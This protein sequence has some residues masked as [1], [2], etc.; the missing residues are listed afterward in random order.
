MFNIGDKV[1]V[2]NING[3]TNTT[4]W[5]RV[6]TEGTVASISV[7]GNAVKLKER[8]HYPFYYLSELELKE[9]VN[10]EMLWEI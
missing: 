8:D 9:P 10:Q 2:A 3:Q 4:V 1:R 7:R 5:S 6:G